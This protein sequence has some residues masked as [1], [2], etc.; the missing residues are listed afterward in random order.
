[1]C[2]YSG[3]NISGNQFWV[4]KVN[5]P[6]AIKALQKTIKFIQE[7]KTILVMS[8]TIIHSWRGQ[9]K[10]PLPIAHI[11]GLSQP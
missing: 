11:H 9:A 10:N 8:K 2:K 3:E 4:V 7:T 6:R 1:M 5:D